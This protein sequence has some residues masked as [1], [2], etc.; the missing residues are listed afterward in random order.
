MIIL[1]EL[2]KEKRSQKK[3]KESVCPMSS[4]NTH[5]TQLC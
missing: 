1:Q 3:R 5:S 4:N 2:T